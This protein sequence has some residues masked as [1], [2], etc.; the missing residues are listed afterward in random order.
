[1]KFPLRNSVTRNSRLTILQHLCLSVKG[2]ARLLFVTLMLLSL[3]QSAQQEVR[4]AESLP[5]LIV[6]DVSGGGSYCS[7]GTGVPIYLSGSEISVNYEL[8]CNGTPTGILLA[9]TGSPLTFPNITTPGV[10]TIRATA[11]PGGE[12]GM[13]NGNAVV[14]VNPILVP[15][16]SIAANPGNTIC[17]GTSVT[18][19]A[20][21]V[22][23]GTAPSFQWKV[24]GVN[25]GTN[26]NTFTSTTLTNGN[27][28]TCV[29]TS[30]AVCASPASVT[31]N[32]LTMTVNALV[33]PAVTIT[34]TQTTFCS[35]TPVT[36]SISV[37]NNGGL[38][39]TYQWR[40]NG[41]PVGTAATYTTS[42]LSNGDVVTLVV[43][44]SATCTTTPTALS[45]AVTVTVTPDA[46]ITRTSAVGTDHQTVC[47][48]TPI[49]PITYATTGA[50]GATF[51]GLPA[52]VTGSWASNIVTISGTPTASGPFNYTVTSTGGCGTAT[53]T[54]SLTV[55]PVNTLTLTSAAGTNAQTVCIN[56]PLTSIT[57]ATT[58][59]TG[60]TFSGLPS[61]VSG[62][63]AS[64][65]VTISGTPS[66]SGTFPYTVTLTGGC[67]NI[68]ANGTI[69]VT[70]N[71]TITLTS[72]V[73]TDA[74]GVCLGNPIVTITYSIGGGGTGAG[75]TGLPAG[76]TGS[77]SGGVFTIS[78][79]PS[80]S[81]TFN[82]TVTTTG[83]CIQATATG[84]I[85]VNQ[86]ASISLTSGNNV[87]TRC[88]NTPIATITYTI[89]GSG[90]GAGVTGL[91]PGVSGSYSGG[92]FTING[93]PTASGTYNYIVTT[94]GSCAQATATGTITVNPNAAITLTSAASTTAQEVCRQS[95]ITNITYAVSGAT[96]FNLTGS[97]PPGVTASLNAGV[98]TISGTPDNSI[99]TTTTYNYT[100]T[101]TGPCINAS[102]SGSIKVF[103]GNPANWGGEKIEGPA[104]VCPPG[105]I[106]FS[107][108]SVS[109]AQYY[110]WTLPPGF[111]I[112]G[113]LNTNSI[114][115][116]VDATAIIGNNQTVS[117][118]AR[119]PCG[120]NNGK[121]TKINVGTFNGVT[122]TPTAQSVCSGGS[123][124]VTGTLTGNAAT[125]TWS[126]PSG[127]FTNIV[128][129]PGPPITVSATYTP[130]IVTGNVTLTIT[131][132]A[133]TGGG[134]PNVPGTATVIVT[135]YQAVAITIQPIPTQTVCSGTNVEM[136]VKAT[137]EG[138]TYQW[139]KGVT[140]LTNGGNVSGATTSTLTLTGVTLADAGL[141][142][143]VVSGIAPCSPV[144]SGNSELIVNGEVV[145]TAH[146]APTQTVC[147]GN[148]VS[149]SV[150]A[151]GTG[152]TYQWRRGIT[153]LTDGGNIS[154]A[155][156]STLTLNPVTPA[157]EA[158]DYNVV[159]TGIPPCAAATSKPAILIVN[160]AVAII[161]QPAASQNV[162]SGTDV[163]FSVTATGDG[164]TWQWRK[165]ATN[166]VNGGSISG[167]NTATLTIN[168]T[169]VSDAGTYSVV[170]SGASPCVSVVS[171]NS[172]LTV[173]Q[174]VIIS[175]QP[176]ATQTVC[177]G[178]SVTLS[179]ATT[180]TGFSYQW[181]RGIINLADGGSLSGVNTSTLTINPVAAGDAASD[182][183]VVITSAPP[184]SPATSDYSALIV[185][186]AVVI[187]SQPAATQTV[188]SGT[189]VSFSVSATGDGL[190]YQ[191]MKGTTNLVNGG[192]VSGA[193]GATL[194]LTGVTVSDAGTYSVVVNGAA[195]CNAVTSTG[196]VLNVHQ[197]I[198]INTQP[199]NTGVCVSEP[200][201]FGVVAT[202]E[203]LAWQWFKGAYPGV[204][205]MNG[206]FITGAQ[207]NIL[208]FSQV[209]LTDAGIYYVE[210]SGVSPCPTVLSDEVT[211]N[212]D[213]SITIT[214]QPASQTACVGADITFSVV[215][216]VSR[217][218]F[219][220]QWYKDGSPLTDG[221]NLSGT[222]TPDL[223]LSSIVAGDAGGY[224]VK[225]TGDVT[226]TCPDVTSYTA[227]L[228]VTPSV[229]TPSAITVAAGTE[230]VCQL[231]NGTTTTT[232]ATTA[233]HNTGFNWTISNPSAGSI[234]PVTGVMT[235]ANG[236]S[237]SVDIMV[238]ANGC[239]GPS[240]PV[241]R[242]VTITPAVGTPTPITIAAGT[243][244]ECQLTNGT[245]TTTYATTATNPTGF[246]WSISDPAAGSINATTGVMTWANGYAGTVDIRVT[247]N[248]CNGPSAEVIRTVT[249]QFTVT[250]NAFSPPTSTRCQGAATITYT[251]TANHSTGITYSLDAVSLAG[252]NTINPV[253][254]EVTF[255]A[256]WSGASTITATA[257]GC[258]GPATTTHVVTIAPTV[259]IV[260]FDP[261]TSARCQGAGTSTYTTTANYTTGIIYSLDAVSLAGGN[262]LN[263]VTGV[264]T[265][266]AG[267]SGIS[268]IT[269]TA[270][271]CNGPATTTHTVT[272]DQAPVGGAINPPVT[273]LCS[274]T[275]EIT[276]N[277]VGYSGS[278]R[279]WEYSFDGGFTWLPINHTSATLTYTI[280]QSMLFR[281]VI[282]RGTCPDAYSA[283][284]VVS[285][286]YPVEPTAV[287]APPVICFG[288]SSVLTA[289]AGAIP[290]GY[291]TGGTFSQANPEGW[292]ITENGTEIIFPAN[293][294]NSEIG[295]WSETNGPKTFCGHLYDSQQGKFAIVNGNLNS[296]MET[297]VFSLAGLTSASLTWWQAFDFKSGAMG[298][299]E[300]STDGGATYHT[301]LAQYNGPATMLPYIGFNQ[302]NSIDLTNY[303]GLPNLRIRYNYTGTVSSSWAV[304]NVMITQAPANTAVINYVWTPN[305]YLTNGGIGPVV[306]ATPPVT[307]LY[308]VHTSLSIGTLTCPLGSATVLVTVL[309]NPVCSIA[310]PAD[311]VCP[312]SSNLYTA[313]AGM[314]AYSWTISG[315][316]TLTGSNTAPEVTV[317][318]GTTCNASYTL[319]LSITDVNGC[320]STC[321]MTSI[322]ND[323]IYP[324]ATNPDPV[325]VSCISDV[326]APDILV[327]DD[328]ADNCGLPAVAFV[329][330]VS[331]GLSCP[332]TITRTYRVTDACLNQITVTQTITVDDDVA[333]VI[334]GVLPD[335]NNEGC[336]VTDIPAAVTTVAALE[337][338]GLS[339]SDNCTADDQLVVTY[340][341]G[342]P[343]GNCPI[344]VV[345]TYTLTDACGN[346]Q[347][348]AQNIYIDDNTPPVIT[349]KIT[350]TQTVTTNPDNIYIHPIDD[351]TWDYE[352][353]SDNCGTV[354]VTAMLSG[355]TNSG[356]HTTL[357]GVTF[358]SGITQVT[359]TAEDACGNTATCDFSV[360]VEGIAD[361]S[362]TKTGPATVAAGQTITYT[363]T[364]TNGGP[365]TTPLVTLTDVVP[366]SVLAPVYSL[367]GVPQGNWSGPVSFN[368][369]AEKTS[370]IIEISGQAAC[371]TTGSI[372]NTALVEAG[373]LID[374]D[375]T[376]N[377]ASVTTLITDDQPPT[378]TV[379]G[380]FSFCVNNLITATYN[381]N[382]TPGIIP[383]YDDITFPRPE[384]YLFSD[385]SILF[386]LDP[387][388]NNFNDN[389]C[390]DEALELHWRIEFSPVPNPATVA[391]ELITEPPIPDQ[392]GQ[393]SEY[394][395]IEFPGD[396]VY[397]TNID[398]HLYYWLVDCNGNPSAEQAL[399][400][401]IKPRPNVV[402][403]P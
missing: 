361:I 274:G 303:L 7:G 265:W 323:L 125:G 235:W 76:V 243:E 21:P 195:P 227:T 208:S 306:T 329:S 79:T 158:N 388:I 211:L 138:L 295:P 184:C 291:F 115:V 393:P 342:T 128:Q 52:G 182:Y 134:C 360:I 96:T 101:T 191:W 74:Q 312:S 311:P 285:I 338:L 95:A 6:Y 49:E 207:S 334:S 181:R 188:C 16:I 218:N 61:G 41:S 304:E 225:I 67:G 319:N 83:T 77:F 82:Y 56:T 183:N 106:Y 34:A 266:S 272:T 192:S 64:G 160:E 249:I 337:A 333:P 314:A 178:T 26:S 321:S 121:A 131:T 239:N 387:I 254:G 168:G 345:R 12:T 331:D 240:A 114:T 327:V 145:I 241:I 70:P 33:T 376:N 123:V 170:V 209:T 245:T 172:I 394:G 4:H 84:I 212:V 203:G 103:V 259:T 398:H 332:E 149:F 355:A 62:S 293:A 28:V 58:G 299:I 119:N 313:P 366:G 157:D 286:V 46:T 357:A 220:Y 264:V 270:P 205:V 341:D 116:Y 161:T 377:T 268:T 368:N 108:A 156:T 94:T 367:D 14:T 47:T 37:L 283:N 392:T 139:R 136:K 233:T 257:A 142:N 180:A 120:T 230:P 350:G 154:G 383:E 148:P 358:N 198:S 200:A 352:S 137:G 318:A 231:T 251:T 194:T 289:T 400:I 385:G 20:T 27:I 246:N 17:A 63:W 177:S 78:G 210:V 3:P 9:G 292:R 287:A 5:I 68:T 320:S 104:S 252:G 130:A 390:E 267:W 351:Y 372:T 232:Y 132:N 11:I 370:H 247:A 397:F 202:G 87:Q 369:M 356:P 43:T 316:G 164:L 107:I 310:G 80:V 127:V 244:P 143:V 330:D 344:A 13:M 10:Y 90:T 213:Q 354:T 140:N 359:W 99:A 117:V 48:G 89:G 129:S 151:T 57:Y 217:E 236:F 92:V 22:N 45:N 98:L 384:Y 223:H 215:A 234:D 375:L 197:A 346:Y 282:Q 378:F 216:N 15:S 2:S 118:L 281:A 85:K 32:A 97:L 190:T 290:I 112:T 288:S 19:T 141:Y 362:V 133:P 122:V 124:T 298:K 336:T 297:P 169:T 343:S 328:E 110:T 248:G 386:D 279:R 222:L 173:S 111:T 228:T 153:N 187:T 73:G 255:D 250:I 65:V 44:S 349:C 175:S 294:D 322:V 277:L 69:I 238:T 179:V 276:L 301:V 324:T 185:H 199:A 147:T 224:Y 93:T 53:G 40:V 278:V 30:N 262:L 176:P 296:T 242:T 401:T 146:P 307:T 163:S 72:A 302:S 226:Y 39:P 381:P 155:T 402:K 364:V 186:Q 206:G 280:T 75:V 86:N 275:N 189:D 403:Q 237:G 335:S 365:A 380:P 23:G 50:T 25:V 273:P 109:N 371:P 363:L 35:G 54:G 309:D 399:I 113:G 100:I 42:T 261:A 51:S 166:L 204:P 165:G 305:T 71:A 18:F 159:V 373:T 391:H 379:P 81:G 38:N 395:D 60:A 219:N 171:A 88:I 196:A 102:V 396:G 340:T 258:N 66:V 135:V 229:G 221:G 105:T 382:P 260:P 325:T 389:C 308:T 144:T 193:D 201:W 150:T 59:A 31:S 174:E 263:A 55:T 347:T 29:L 253:T 162:C 167:A 348:V 269:A 91:P 24:N 374:P 8:V 214:T 152:L 36:F 317:L 256:G 126:A 300:I 326:P 284:A 339:I 353:A 271:G 1:M 315:N